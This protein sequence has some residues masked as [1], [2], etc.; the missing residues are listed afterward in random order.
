MMWDT[1][2][3]TFLLQ[4]GQGGGDLGE[5]R[6][7]HLPSCGNVLRPPFP[8]GQGFVL[9]RPREAV[10]QGPRRMIAAKLSVA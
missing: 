4:R 8:E 2:Y 5:P 9:E 7:E 3:P 1:A 10:G 6:K